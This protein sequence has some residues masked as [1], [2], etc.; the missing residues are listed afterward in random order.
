MA[1]GSEIA[2]RTPSGLGAVLRAEGAF[3]R[4]LWHLS[5]PRAS[6]TSFIVP[7]TAFAR[8]AERLDCRSA[9]APRFGVSGG[10]G[11]TSAGA[12]VGACALFTGMAVATVAGLALLIRTRGTPSSST[13][14][15]RADGHALRPS[16]RSAAGALEKTAVPE[17]LTRSLPE[18]RGRRGTGFAFKP[19]TSLI[20]S[21]DRGA[22]EVESSLGASRRSTIPRR[23][24]SRRRIAS[25]LLSCR[26]VGRSARHLSAAAR[27]SWAF[28]RT[29]LRTASLVPRTCTASMRGVVRGRAAALPKGSWGQTAFMSHRPVRCGRDVEQKGSCILACNS[30]RILWRTA[31]VRVQ[32]TPPCSRRF[33]QA[34]SRL[35]AYCPVQDDHAA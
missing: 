35:A 15:G 18:A 22:F 30:F 27:A 12:G 4:A 8:L 16:T 13:A 19:Y 31:V 14:C 34:R 3:V 24:P 21:I 32:V 1:F 5:S 20:S 33:A 2:F 6:L 9:T 11:A 28:C 26:L 25:M 29:E 17:G 23:T 7:C 10:R